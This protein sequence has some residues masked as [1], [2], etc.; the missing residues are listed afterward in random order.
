ME[1]LLELKDRLK[2]FYSKYEIYMMPVL[3]FVL[4]FVLFRGGKGHAHTAAH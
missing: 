4:A 1:T 3:K 2:N